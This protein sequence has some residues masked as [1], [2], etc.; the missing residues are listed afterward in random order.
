MGSAPHKNRT[1]SLHDEAYAAFVETLVKLRKESGL[2]QHHIAK[3][4]GWNQSVVSKI[5][6]CQRRIDVIELIRVGHVGGV[7]AASLVR[8]IQN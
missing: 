5:E 4:L 6:N 7:D 2:K 3:A 8:R 1:A